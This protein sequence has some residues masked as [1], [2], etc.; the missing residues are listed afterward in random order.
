MKFKEPQAGRHGGQQL[1]GRKVNSVFKAW[2]GTPNELRALRRP[3]LA[4]PRGADCCAAALTATREAKKRRYLVMGRR[5]SDGRLTATFI[6]PWTKDKELKRARRMF[7]R[8][9]CANLA[10][11][12]QRLMAE[13]LALRSAFPGEEDARRR[14]HHNNRRGRKNARGGP[15][16]RRHRRRHRR[17]QKVGGENKAH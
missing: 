8:I 14:R 17:G 6:L 3:R 4:L 2:R 7:K 15:E 10:N 12:G 1:I 9:D 5:E 16:R 13:A 11:D